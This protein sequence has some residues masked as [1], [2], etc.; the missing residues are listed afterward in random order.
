MDGHHTTPPG[1]GAP[2]VARSE[3]AVRRV[4]RVGRQDMLMRLRSGRDPFWDDGQGARRLRLRK[5]I[6]G[7]VALMIA[8]VGLS[9]PLA[10]IYTQVTSIEGLDEN[11]E[12]DAGTEQVYS[13]RR[14]ING[15]TYRIEYDRM[16]YSPAELRNAPPIAASSDSRLQ[17]LLVVPRSNYVTDLVAELT[18]GLDTQYDT[19]RALYQRQAGGSP[20]DAV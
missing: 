20:G 16:A 19:V 6:T 5:R 9:M 8:I 11:W 4:A 10:P 13:H 14:N 3:P 17:Q 1:D 7:N 15:A 2:E 18:A 12:L